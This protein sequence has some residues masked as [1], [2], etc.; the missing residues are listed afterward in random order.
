MKKTKLAQ[1]LATTLAGSTL[2]LGAASSVSA[3]TM[4]NTYI[5]ASGVDGRLASP[6]A[7]TT[8]GALPFNY[9]GAQALNWAV[10]L[11]GNNPQLNSETI[12][13]ADA[14]AQHGIT[15]KID[16]TGG[17]WFKESLFT[18]DGTGWSMFLDYGLIKSTVDMT[19][20]IAAKSLYPGNNGKLGFTVFT[21]MDTGTGFNRHSPWNTTP[22]YSFGYMPRD[23]DNPFGT[24]DLI[25]HGHVAPDETGYN[26]ATGETVYTLQMAADQV[27]TIYLGGFESADTNDGYEVTFT[28]TASPVPIPGAAWLMG[29]GLIA[30]LGKA[31]R[32]KSLT[33]G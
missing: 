30:L 15:A 6:W 20:T 19:L 10:L 17:A 28:P 25:Y 1:A 4:Y 26:T 5:P 22:N 27:Y 31:R 33:V 32:K 18:G 11:E 24:D 14:L 7:G 29:S 9:S 2:F 23:T 3:S 8:G 21:G 13:A 16:T 12:S